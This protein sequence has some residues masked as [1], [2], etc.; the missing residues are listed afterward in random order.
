MDW[1]INDVEKDLFKEI[2]N[3]GLSKAADSLALL[4]K[5][6]V[7]LNVPEIKLTNPS[8]LLE[9]VLDGHNSED[10]F[11]VQSDIKGELEGKTLLLFS[12]PHAEKFIAQIL[13]EIGPFDKKKKEMKESLLLEVSNIITGSIITQ[14]ANIFNIRIYGDIPR[15][16]KDNLEKTI[17]KITSEFSN[18]QP[19]IFTI[20]T[21]FTNGEPLVVLPLMVIFDTDTLLK[22]LS[23]LR[24]SEHT[25]S[26]SF[27][28]KKA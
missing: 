10:M 9:V 20:K 25:K 23:Y 16:P 19:L 24:S 4:A 22:L 3:I 5:H 15:L 26:F 28:S 21:K 12:R 14:F 13:S 17:E 7:L 2:A 6:K 18:F 27:L 1:L 11:A 8:T